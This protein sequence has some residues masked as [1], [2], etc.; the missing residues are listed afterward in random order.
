[1]ALDAT[2]DAFLDLQN[3]DLG[4]ELCQQTLDTSADIEHFENFLL[5]LELQGQMCGNG[6]GKTPRILDARD[7]G[8]DL[9]RDFLVELDVLIELRDHCTAQGLDLM[10]EALVSK[11]RASAR[12]KHFLAR[13]DGLQTRALCP[14]DQYLHGTVRQLQH[15]QDIG[16]TA[17]TI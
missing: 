9:R 17:N 4:F 7:R 6:I 14:F 1:M 13:V 16:H 2:T 3:V 12:E 8:Q 15:L 5:L 11:H 10:I